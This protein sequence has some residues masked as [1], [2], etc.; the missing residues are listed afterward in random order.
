MAELIQVHID[1]R[2]NGQS[3][4]RLHRTYTVDEVQ[5]FDPYEKAADGGDTTFVALPV[6]EVDSVKVLAFHA[7]DQALGLRAEGGE[8]TN[9]AIRH[10]VGGFLVAGGVTIPDSVLTVNNNAG[11]TAK[12]RG[13]AAGT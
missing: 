9:V 2:V 5:Y 13:L 10:D 8:A 12:I 7:V 1:I 11:A 4:F 3:R 6:G